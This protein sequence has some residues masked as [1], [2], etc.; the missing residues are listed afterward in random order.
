MSLSMPVD[1]NKSPYFATIE[2]ES[3]SSNQHVLREVNRIGKH[4]ELSF[5]SRLNAQN[6]EGNSLAQSIPSSLKKSDEAS[7]GA[8]DTIIV[9]H[10]DD[11]GV[12]SELVEELLENIMSKESQNPV[13]EED[14]MSSEATLIT[15]EDR[16]EDFY[17]ISEDESK[18]SYD[19]D[20][21]LQPRTQN[22][23][24]KTSS[25]HDA[26][27]T[28]PFGFDS[29]EISSENDEETGLKNIPDKTIKIVQQGRSK[30]YKVKREYVMDRKSNKFKPAPFIPKTTRY[31]IE[32]DITLVDYIVR[33]NGFHLVK[34]RSFWLEAELEVA[35][36][37]RRTWQSLK[38]RFLRYIVPFINTPQYSKISEKTR[39]HIRTIDF[40]H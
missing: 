4:H 31:S 29:F 26:S 28:Y 39:N 21:E 27:G 14:A 2:S 16:Q 33:K 30:L 10:Q 5:P 19:I 3:T 1:D 9:Y 38:N 7:I 13:V 20:P 8:L 35:S 11:E 24:S 6:Q 36:G 17:S 32:E 23:S 40:N 34:G 15:D 22:E 12:I 37:H 18:E 25:S